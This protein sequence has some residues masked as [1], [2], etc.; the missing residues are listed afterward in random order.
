[1]AKVAWLGLGVMGYPMAGHLK[2]RGGHDVVVY[3]RSPRKPPN[4]VSSS[5]AKRHRRQPKPRAIATLYSPVSATTMT[6]AA[7][8]Q[9]LTARFNR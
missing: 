8:R 1:M 3:N 9:G 4:G 6:C 5:E 7:S 2:T